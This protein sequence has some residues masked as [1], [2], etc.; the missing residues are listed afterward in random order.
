MLAEGARNM[1]TIIGVIAVL[2]FIYLM[3][4]NTSWRRFGFFVIAVLGAGI[5]I[6]W[7]IGERSDREWRARQEA[8]RQAIPH[9]QVLFRDL[10]LQGSRGDLLSGVIYN[11]SLYPIVSVDMRVR[12]RE[13][14]RNED[15]TECIIVGEDTRTITVSVPPGQAR[16]FDTFFSFGATPETTDARTFSAELMQVTAALS[17]P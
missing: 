16:Q 1:T 6:L 10:R 8:A 11:R 5:L 14:A 12:L 15:G 9:D 7:Q 4:V 3:F 17:E 2:G 13:C